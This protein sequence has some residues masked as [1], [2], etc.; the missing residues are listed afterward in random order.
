MTV[1]NISISVRTNADKAAAKLSS[2]ASAMDGVK[3]SADAMSAGTGDI[4][5]HISRG[6]KQATKA[7]EPL[8][9]DMQEAISDA[10]KYDVLVHKAAKAQID[11]DKAF[12]KG[13]EEGAWN[14]RMREINATAQA[15]KELE[16]EQAKLNEAPTN[17]VPIDTQEFI[18]AA[19]AA[20]ILKHKL[21]ELKYAQQ[22]AFE[23]GN[24]DKAWALQSQINST[25]TQLERAE[26]AAHGTA[27]GI[28]DVSAAAE[29]SKSPLNSF[30][31]SL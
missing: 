28:E 5:V 17:P 19:D 18:K 14:A 21:E 12:E 20:E 13:N 23:S 25:A 27:R 8:A 15:A 3:K 24:T 16:K 26:S 22:E 31:K 7:F 30:L 29:K 9:K 6:T 10:S 2:L 4:F 1:E 11:M